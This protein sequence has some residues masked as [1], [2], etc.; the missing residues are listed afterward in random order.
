[1][2]NDLIFKVLYEILDGNVESVDC[3]FGG[4]RRV[5]LITRS[6]ISYKDF[7]RKTKHIVLEDDIASYDDEEDDLIISLDLTEEFVNKI[8]AHVKCSC[9]NEFEN[10]G[11]RIR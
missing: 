7:I 8:I 6:K 3:Y 4:S 1:M 10:M 2:L 9:I 11:K 5:G